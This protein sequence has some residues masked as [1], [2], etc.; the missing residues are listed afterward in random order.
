MGTHLYTGRVI[1]AAEAERRGIVSRS[2]PSDELMDTALG[3]AEEIA[4]NSPFGVWMT[5]EVLWSNL[6]TQSMRA[7]IDIENRNQILAAQT[8]D[9]KAAMKGFLSGNIP[10]WENR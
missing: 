4:A 10:D 5:K 2:V 3:V 6:E 8:E 7:G 1:D 9:S